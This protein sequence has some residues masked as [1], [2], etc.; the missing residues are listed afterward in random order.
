MLLKSYVDKLFASLL[1]GEIDTL[2]VFNLKNNF[3]KEMFA[4]R[5]LIYNDEAYY[6]ALL[7]IEKLYEILCA[8]NFKLYEESVI[9]LSRQEL[10]AIKQS[11]EQ[12]ISSKAK[13]ILNGKEIKENDFLSKINDLEAL[14]ENTLKVVL[15]NPS[16]FKFFINDLLEI[17]TL[18]TS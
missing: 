18:I 1:L 4:A 14:Y 15:K 3:F 2:N 12:I 5:K 11:L 9:E 17:N 13:A 8:V 6:D 16:D 10:L 7:N